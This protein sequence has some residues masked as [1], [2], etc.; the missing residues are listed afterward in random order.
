MIAMRI[1]K[2]RARD[3]KRE[4]NQ[5]ANNFLPTLSPDAL[6][7]ALSLKFVFRSLK[8]PSDVGAVHRDDER[9]AQDSRHH[10]WREIIR[11]LYVII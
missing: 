2:S 3:Q 11:K 9:A 4:L 5:S 1:L 8:Q 10:G 6:F 7:L